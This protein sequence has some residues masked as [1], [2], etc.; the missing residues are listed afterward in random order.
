MHSV[1][2]C[3][4]PA[5]RPLGPLG[6]TQPRSIT[7]GQCRAERSPGPAAPSAAPRALGEAA[8]PQTP[9]LHRPQ[10]H[11][12][13]AAAS[14]P[15]RRISHARSWKDQ[16]SAR[17]R[18]W[19]ESAAPLPPRGMLRLQ[20]GLS[21]IT[22]PPARPTITGP[23]FPDT[24]TSLSPSSPPSP[25]YCSAHG[26]RCNPFPI[27][28]RLRAGAALQHGSARPPSTPNPGGSQS[29][30]PAWR[31]KKDPIKKGNGD[32]IVKPF[33][34]IYL[35]TVN[36][37]GELCAFQTSLQNSGL[38]VTNSAASQPPADKRAQGV[39]WGGG[40]KKNLI[41]RTPRLHSGD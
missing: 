21:P 18:A 25:F 22:P 8:A 29:H 35:I 27:G 15:S 20:E 17:L 9:R 39:G 4:I 32:G 36:I 14:R 6:A 5:L 28:G 13:A 2:P 3:T 34:Y 11:R 7:A 41:K 1:L 38:A 10:P 19:K 30:S 37:R 12:D 26:A 23:A 24:Q 40:N 31:R 16:T 33:N